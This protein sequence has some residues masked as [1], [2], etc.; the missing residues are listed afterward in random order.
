[1]PISGVEAGK[2][3]QP[4]RAECNHHVRL[5]LAVASAFDQTM[6]QGQIMPQPQSDSRIHTGIR[7]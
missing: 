7:A 6:M 2:S 1:M 4:A 5:W 3:I